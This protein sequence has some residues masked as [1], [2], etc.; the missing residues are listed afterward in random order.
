MIDGTRANPHENLL[1]AVEHA[2]SDAAA[3]SAT[4][5]ATIKLLNDGGDHYLLKGRT[6][7]YLSANIPGFPSLDLIITTNTDGPNAYSG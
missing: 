6:S 3:Y 7:K 1:D 4:F 5:T 2:Q